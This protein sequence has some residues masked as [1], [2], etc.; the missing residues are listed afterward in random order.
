MTRKELEKLPREELIA[1]AEE[2]GVVR[3]RTLT[4][5]E[6]VDEILVTLEKRTGQKKPRGWFGKAR[7]LLTSVVDR[8]LVTDPIR[9]SS[10]RVAPAAP[11][12]LPTVTLAEIYAA[13]GHFERAITT[14][15]EVLV[16]DPEHPEARKLHARFSD[17]LRRT[18]PS[19]TP[20]PP[21]GDG[22]TRRSDPGPA[23]AQPATHGDTGAGT[24][25]H[26]GHVPAKAPAAADIPVEVLEAPAALDDRSGVDEVVAI[27]VDPHTLYVYWEVRPSTLAELRAGA[28][29]G[30]LV[31]RVLTVAPLGT[32][33]GGPRS[34][35]RDVRIDALD[36]DIFVRDLPAAAE[37]RVAIGWL[38]WEGATSAFSPIAVGLELSTPREAPVE[39]VATHFGRMSTGG[40]SEPYDAL[41]AGGIIGDRPEP[42]FARPSREEISLGHAAEREGVDPRTLG[43]GAVEITRVRTGA[44][45]VSI[46]RTIRRGASEL[47]VSERRFGGASEELVERRRGGASSL[48]GRD[49][50]RARAEGVSFRPPR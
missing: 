26:E 18:R 49:T 43:E 42:A 34:V 17:Q 24:H 29:N 2:Y 33:A 9:R 19:S 23:V 15:D 6:L 12:P 7:D 22:A 44:P 13:Q 35:A 39:Q 20:P 1:K 46:E 14:L 48:L 45:S 11:P 36:G 32:S 31:L 3:P 4:M 50:K 8:G 41:R 10:S 25:A 37:V 16:R 30:A 21:A 5:P 40:V 47:L 28:P 38:A 27:A